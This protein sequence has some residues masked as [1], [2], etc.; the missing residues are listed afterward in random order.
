MKKKTRNIGS[1]NNTPNATTVKTGI[2]MSSKKQNF[3]GQ[4]DFK[5]RDI[6][7]Q[8][9]YKHGNHYHYVLYVVSFEEMIEPLWVEQWRNP[10]GSKDLEKVCLV[11]NYNHPW[12]KTYFESC[13]GGKKIGQY[14]MSSI[15]MGIQSIYC[16]APELGINEETIQKIIQRFFL[17]F[18]FSL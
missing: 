8:S 13:Y 18:S 3:V 5:N 16:L 4:K 15:A 12:Y 14:L 17:S 7:G 10:D 1:K 6:I 11:F 2:T 9:S